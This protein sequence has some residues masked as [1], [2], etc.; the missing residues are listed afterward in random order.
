MKML[1]R[2]YEN[3][4]FITGWQMKGCPRCG[5]DLYSFFNEDFSCLQCGWV[6]YSDKGGKYH[7]KRK[8]QKKVY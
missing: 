5:G 4:R 2:E 8:S 7:A 6:D 1:S 3:N